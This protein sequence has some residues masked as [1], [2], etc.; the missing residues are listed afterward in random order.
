MKKPKRSP[1]TPNRLLSNQGQGV[2][3]D[4]VRNIRNQV[5]KEAERLRRRSRHRVVGPAHVRAALRRVVP[6]W[7][8]GPAAT[9]RNRD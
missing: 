2:M 1:S 7:R 5:S 3:A 8:W 9:S 4:F 6:E